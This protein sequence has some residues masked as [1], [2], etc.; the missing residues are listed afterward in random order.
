MGTTQSFIQQK[1]SLL[2]LE[3]RIARMEVNRRGADGA[4]LFMGKAWDCKNTLKGKNLSG[5]SGDAKR[6]FEIAAIKDSA[7]A[8]AT[9]WDFSKNAAGELT[10]SATKERLKSIGIDKFEKLEFVYKTANPAEGRIVLSSR[11]SIQGHLERSNPGIVWEL[12][13]IKIEAKA[14]ETGP[15]ALAAGD[16]VT[17]CSFKPFKEPCGPG[18]AGAPH[19]N[20]GGFVAATAKA[21]VDATA[22]IGPDAAVC[23]APHVTQNARVSGHAKVYE[24]AKVYSNAKVYGHAE[25]YGNA[26]VYQSA[27]VYGNAK[28]YGHAHVREYSRVY[29]DARVYGYTEIVGNA[30]VYGNAK[31]QGNDSSKFLYVA[32]RAKIHEDAEIY[33]SAQIRNRAEVH[34]NAAV[35]DSAIIKSQARLWG[36]ARI[37]R[38]AQVFGSASVWGQTRVSN[39]AKVFGNAKVHGNAEISGNAKVFGNANV[40]FGT[41][42]GGDIA[43]NC[44]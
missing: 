41:H 16:R 43:G 5:S 6:A 34:G 38:N 33:G 30:R 29:E 8:P 36:N 19:S 13:G 11:T 32:E 10:H 24:S 7:A 26:K 18:V 9:V 21:T 42:T 15:P 35:T 44:S 12:S 4:Q 28:V 25:I 23:G 20:G 2:A 14:A 31:L 40:C 3:K 37:N 22:F 1:I 17:V 39:Q 27:R